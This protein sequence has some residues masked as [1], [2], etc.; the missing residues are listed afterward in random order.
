MIIVSAP[1]WFDLEK[2]SRNIAD[3]TFS[4][5]QNSPI[6]KSS[7]KSAVWGTSLE[8]FQH[9]IAIFRGSLPVPNDVCTSP[10][11][12][13]VRYK[14]TA[15][16][17]NTNAVQSNYIKTEVHRN[18]F[19]TR[20]EGVWGS[21][22]KLHS[23]LTC[24]LDGGQVH[25]STDWPF[26]EGYTSTHGIRD[27]LGPGVG[28]GAFQGSLVLGRPACSLVTTPTTLPRLPVACSSL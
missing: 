26:G 21:G 6:L 4:P 22:G 1:F 25:T 24:A 2:K 27:W 13:F 16:T 11:V 19:C 9:H 14:H 28:L 18:C 20:H 10:P 15:V 7:R 23:F 17:F 8:L 5:C 3:I 12:V